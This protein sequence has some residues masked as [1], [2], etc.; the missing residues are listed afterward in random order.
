MNKTAIL[1]AVTLGAGLGLASYLM[2]G[3]PVTAPVVIAEEGGMVADSL[4]DGQYWRR[5][6]IAS[7]VLQYDK[8]A[9]RALY[10]EHYIAVGPVCQAPV[11]C[12]SCVS[13]KGAARNAV[14]HANTWIRSAAKPGPDYAAMMR[15]DKLVFQ[16]SMASQRATEAG[17]QA[18]D[19]VVRC[20]AIYAGAD[21]QCKK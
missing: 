21:I 13:H 5:Q 12:T 15:Q 8:A 2:H 19:H 3:K 14:I 6:S 20:Q 7:D 16:M 10:G 1:T 18:Y 17:R 11:E 9:C 4:A